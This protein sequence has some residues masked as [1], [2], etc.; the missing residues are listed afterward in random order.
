M[1]SA[2]T[3]WKEIAQHLGKGVRTVQRW[4]REGLPVRRPKAGQKGRVLA[5]PEEI[6]RW[7]RAEYTRND[8]PGRVNTA[9]LSTA[10]DQLLAENESLR[11]DLNAL[12]GIQVT[13][14]V[15]GHAN[16]SLLQR[17]SRALEES[18]VVRG[19]FAE[20]MQRNAPFRQARAAAVDALKDLD[21]L[22]AKSEPLQE[23]S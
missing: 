5:F 20:L 11:R 21:A 19:R 17:C 9:A 22:R 16:V 12:M 18:M 10:V 3:S 14:N 4:E 8:E 6:D 13:P 1:A 7:V 2:L 15:D 23:E